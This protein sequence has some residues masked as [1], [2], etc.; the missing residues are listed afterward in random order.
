MFDSEFIKRVLIVVPATMKTYWEEEL[1]KWCY[2]C[3]NIERFED[4]KKSIR[5][6]QMKRIRRKGGILLTSYGMVSTERINL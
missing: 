1:N 3:P 5:A 4:S 6:E 2:D